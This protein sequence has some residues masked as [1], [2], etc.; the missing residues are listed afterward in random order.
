MSARS[1]CVLAVALTILTLAPGVL[2]VPRPLSAER[3][4]ERADVIATGAVRRIYVSEEGS[5]TNYLA[6]ITV[7]SCAKGGLETMDV[8]TVRY[9]DVATPPFT[10]G[11]SGHTGRPAVGERVVVHARGSE[12]VREVLFPNGFAEAEP[13]MFIQVHDAEAYE[14]IIDESVRTD[15]YLLALE[16]GAKRLSISWHDETARTLVRMSAKTG[17]W[18]ETFDALT[19]YADDEAH[20]R[21]AAFALLALAW[22]LRGDETLRDELETLARER[23]HARLL[24]HLGTMSAWERDTSRA[25]ELFRDAIAMDPSLGGEADAPGV[26]HH[27][28]ACAERAGEDALGAEWLAYAR[29]TW[30]DQRRNWDLLEAR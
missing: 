25:L 1:L 14:G 15:R 30:P 19:E 22:E 7:E 17:R 16:Y 10:A 29:E 6:E 20:G 3:L 21:D 26:Y 27:A 28:I 12:G 23:E 5:R 8:L 24:G 4:D 11:S 13:L 2:A 9:H 18:E